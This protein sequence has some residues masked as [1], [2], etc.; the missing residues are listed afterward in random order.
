[1]SGLVPLRVVVVAPLRFPIRRPHAGGLESAV[2]NE[3]DQLRARGHDVTLIA[4]EGSDWLGEP[5]DF[6]IPAMTWPGA[7]RPTDD[8]Y[9]P[10]YAARSV[11]ALGRALDRIA[12]T[13]ADYDVI[14][15]HCLHGLPLE[16][17][18]GLGVPMVST[19]H[20][21]VDDE[22]V[23]SHAAASGRRSEFLSVSEHTRRQWAD[24]GIESTVLANAVDP[25]AWPLGPGG[26]DLVWFGRIV[27]EKAPH[28]AIEVAERLGRGLVIAGRIGDELYADRAVLSR[29]GGGIRYVGQLAPS[30]LAT[31]VGRSAALIATPVW[32]EPFGLVAPEALMS[33]TPV[34]SFAMGGVSEIAA[35]SVGMVTVPSG[36]VSAMAKRVEHMIGRAFREPGFR[37]AIRNSAEARFSL[38]ARI[39]A[40]ERR[41][42]SMVGD[43]ESSSERAA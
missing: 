28:L 38:P 29:V 37:P 4:A 39:A 1:M 9:P 11:P 23:A 34:V 42:R 41:F 18:G 21:P 43:S 36:D 12:A 31:L 14:S 15:N 10:S 5:S 35:G 22:L 24:A 32:E 30:E 6:T 26:P 19:L 8:T 20:T 3:V 7:S 17:A 27:P 40:L 16:R 2:W 25:Q 33:G 13:A